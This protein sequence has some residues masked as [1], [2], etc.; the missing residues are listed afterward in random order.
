MLT[1]SERR[2]DLI[3]ASL[4]EGFLLFVLALLGWLVKWPFV[5]ASLG[6]TAYELVEQPAAR[7]ARTYNIIVGHLVGLGSGFLSLWMLD[8]WNAPKV[9]TAGYMAEP[10]AWAIVISA[11]LTTI[12]MLAL[13]AGQPAAIATALLVSLGSMQTGRD[14]VA[15]IVAVLVIAAIGEP[16]RRLRLKV[17]GPSFAATQACTPPATAAP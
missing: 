17:A 13:K 10:R 3:F 2:R 8:A 5:F 14:A 9:L 15:I 11:V 16:L 7:S 4:G 12:G 6:P 1:G